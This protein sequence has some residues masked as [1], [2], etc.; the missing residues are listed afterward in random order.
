MPKGSVLDYIFIVVFMAVLFMTFTIALIINDSASSEMV[1]ISEDTPA[2][3]DVSYIMDY[4]REA[5]EVFDYLF[6]LLYIGLCII[7]IISAY[8]IES[9]PVL[10]VVDILVL[11]VLYMVFPLISN[12]MLTFFQMPQTSVYVAGGGSEVWTYSLFI[13]Q[14]LPVLSVAISLLII[15][16]TFIRVGT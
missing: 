11:L 5:L 13:F 9:H 12:V 1:R 14:Y 8:L 3:D 10:V 2:E 15:I 6:I 4:T 16:A 7:P